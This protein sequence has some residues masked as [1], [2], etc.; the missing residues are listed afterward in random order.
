MSVVANGDPST[1]VV[2]R[3]QLRVT[4]DMV[5]L[6]L[7]AAVRFFIA[8]GECLRRRRA[9]SS[10]ISSISSWTVKVILPTS[11]AT[12][13]V[14]ARIVAAGSSR[15][16][17]ALLGW[18]GW[19]WRRWRSPASRNRSLVGCRLTADYSELPLHVAAHVGVLDFV[20]DAAKGRQCLI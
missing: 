4:V 5:L 19:S 18:P 15:P 7:K 1:R 6:L 11:A 17:I 14:A 20:D 2:G 8:L 12:R 10:S 16:R 3:V 13:I 9:I